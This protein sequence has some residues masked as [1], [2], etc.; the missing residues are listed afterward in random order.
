M[1]G[2][3]RS[4]NIAEGMHNGFRCL[5][6]CTNPAIWRFIAF[7][8]KEQDLTKWKIT[9]KMLRRPPLLRQKKWVDN[10]RR[11]NAVIDSYDDYDRLDYLKCVEQ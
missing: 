2:L 3:P 5:M 10:D 1:A 7:L 9:Q 6:G 11:L 8:K 4:S